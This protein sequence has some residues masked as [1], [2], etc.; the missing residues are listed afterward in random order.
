MLE[1]LARGKGTLQIRR[2]RLGVRP[3]SGQN[4]TRFRNRESQKLQKP[5]RRQTRAS[6]NDRH[7]VRVHWVVSWNRDDSLPVR[8]DNVFSFPDYAKS[9]LLQGA[10]GATMGNPGDSH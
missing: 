10:N 3:A 6:H 2:F 7:R 1:V 8:H 4:Q 9:G 5:L